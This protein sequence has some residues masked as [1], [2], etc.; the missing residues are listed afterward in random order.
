MELLQAQSVDLLST[1]L[2]KSITLGVLAIGVWVMWKRDERYRKQQDDKMGRLEERIENY[3]NTDRDKILKQLERSTEVQHETNVTLKAT[4]R[5]LE[6]FIGEMTEFKDSELYK[7]YLKS[8][9][10]ERA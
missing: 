3:E 8:R 2:D 7:S 9:K 6:C 4:N 5:I 1:I 10:S